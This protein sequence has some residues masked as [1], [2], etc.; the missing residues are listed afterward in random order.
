MG[1][2]DYLYARPSFAGGMARLF[3]FGR[4]LNVFNESPN[5]S[6]AD[7]KAFCEDW[8]AVA[9]DLREVL[10]RID[11]EHHGHEENP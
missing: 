2:T 9:S 7:T 10:N 11:Q 6:I 5:G 8:R 3:D 4:T 1:H